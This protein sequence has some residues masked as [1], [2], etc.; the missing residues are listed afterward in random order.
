MIVLVVEDN[1]ID[2]KLA[3][4]VLESAGYEAQVR[5]SSEGV[6]EATRALRPDIILLDLYL[7]RIDGLSIVAELRRHWDTSRIPIVAITAYPLRYQPA[8]VLA[9]GCSGCIIKPIDTREL[10]N[11]IR[12][13]VANRG[14]GGQP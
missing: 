6:L 2:L 4:A 5:T 14:P 10:A 8:E 1:P 13:V 9:A 12:A 7:P 11:Q 3:R